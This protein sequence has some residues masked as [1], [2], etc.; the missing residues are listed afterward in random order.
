MMP[1]EHRLDRT[2]VIQ[3]SPETVFRY[4]TDSARW[5]A[6]WG[7]GSTIDA[8]PGGRVYV[9][10]ATGDEAAG[11]VLEVKPPE[12][13]VFSYGYVRGTPMPVGAS[14]VTIDLEPLEGA[15]RL[16]LSHELGDAAA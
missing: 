10:Y 5:A 7:A 8:R 2:V 13:I 12:R 11:E 1:L 3:A 15:T 6:W 14:R 16:R 9:R 4:F